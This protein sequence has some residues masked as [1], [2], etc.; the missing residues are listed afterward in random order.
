MIWVVEATKE[1]I[2]QNRAKGKITAVGCLS[3]EI[4]FSS[5]RVP[6]D[7]EKKKLN[8]FSVRS[9]EHMFLG[10]EGFNRTGSKILLGPYTWVARRGM[11][12][13]ADWKPSVL[14]NSYR[15]SNIF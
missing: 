12:K 3:D 10:A 2:H 7:P 15:L 14:P 5:N 8:L 11:K 1:V 9:Q 6:P 13:K 4:L